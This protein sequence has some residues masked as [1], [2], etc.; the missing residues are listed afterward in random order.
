MIKK[1]GLELTKWY[2]LMMAKLKHFMRS[3]NWWKLEYELSNSMCFCH[4]E[5]VQENVQS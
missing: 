1:G 5:H 2:I 3:Y 4:L